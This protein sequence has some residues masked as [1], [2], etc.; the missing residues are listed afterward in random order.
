MMSR[1]CGLS[2]TLRFIYLL[3]VE[4]NDSVWLKARYEIHEPLEWEKIIIIQPSLVP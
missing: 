1:N 2:G 4:W 3:T